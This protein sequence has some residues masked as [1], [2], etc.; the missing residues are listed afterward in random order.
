MLSG[1]IQA[2]PAVA[3]ET[4]QQASDAVT[5]AII[6]SVAA[7]ATAIIAVVGNV[8]TSRRL[9]KPNG[10]GN[11]VQMNELQLKNHRDMIESQTE[12]RTLL[13]QHLGNSEAHGGRIVTPHPPAGH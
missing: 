12:I 10:Q 4:A 6:S 7:I 3:L 5:L 1:F 13:M 2:D 8:V 9:G 11:V